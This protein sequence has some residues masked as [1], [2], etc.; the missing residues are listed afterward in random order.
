MP[1]V[2]STVSLLHS[3]HM[4]RYPLVML[5]RPTVYI[6]AC[7]PSRSASLIT[8]F[9]KKQDLA[10]QPEAENLQICNHRVLFLETIF[11]ELRIKM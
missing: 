9:Y 1:I 5:A 2:C 11:V 7:I 10:N 4:V 6:R 8:Q 3:W